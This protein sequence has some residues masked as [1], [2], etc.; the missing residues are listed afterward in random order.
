[1]GKSTIRDIVDYV[2]YVHEKFPTVDKKTIERVL[3]FGFKKI[4]YFQQRNRNIRMASKGEPV[5]NTTYGKSKRKLY[6]DMSKATRIKWNMKNDSFSGYYYFALTEEEC[7][8]LNWERLQKGLSVE[9]KNILIFKNPI[10]LHW[11]R[12]KMRVHYFALEYPVDLG[13]NIR[14]NKIRSKNY[15]YL[16]VCKTEEMLLTNLKK[17]GIRI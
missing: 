3:L 16:G 17:V 12:S 15:K 6:N 10:E 14:L 4:V 8:A 1:M 2:D 7:E 13:F 5:I 11:S 9:F